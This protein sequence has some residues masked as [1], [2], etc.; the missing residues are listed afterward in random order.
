[1]NQ[2]QKNEQ[3]R[4]KIQTKIA[5]HHETESGWVGD[6][7]QPTVSNSCTRFWLQNCNGLPTT[8]D[9]NWFQY[10]LKNVT[11]NNIH[12]Y[13][14]PESNIN[15]SNGDI[16]SHLGQIHQNV[17]Q[18]G[19]FTITNTKGYPHNHKYQPGGIS[20]GFHGRLEN[21][22][23]CTRRDKYGRWHYHEFFGKA[24]Q[25]RV[26]TL[27]RVNINNNTTGGSTAWAQQQRALL[28]ENNDTNPRTHVIDV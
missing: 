6:S 20:S 10:D 17:V 1:M 19:V 14:F 26:Y 23:A 24:N 27:Y 4:K 25:M 12:Y 8:K 9:K 28:A 15:A 13:A 18:S 22:Y 11:D 2:K 3:K 5:H 16:T 21:R 7:M